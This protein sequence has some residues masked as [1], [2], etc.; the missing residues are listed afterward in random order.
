LE[1][2]QKAAQ[3]AIRQR[4]RRHRDEGQRAQRVM[5]AA[6]NFKNCFICFSLCFLYDG[7]GAGFGP[8]VEMGCAGSSRHPRREKAME[9]SLLPDRRWKCTAPRA[10]WSII[11]IQYPKH[12]YPATIT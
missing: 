2:R 4:R 9:F 12:G 7:F 6:L 5:G 3:S 8:E 1:R 10:H 11:I